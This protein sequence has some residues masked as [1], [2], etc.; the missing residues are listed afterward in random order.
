MQTVLRFVA[1]AACLTVEQQSAS[2]QDKPRLLA[3]DGFMSK[4]VFTELDPEQMK[5]R[6]SRADIERLHLDGN[7]TG[8]DNILGLMARSE[9]MHSRIAEPL[10]VRGE[11]PVTLPPNATGSEAY[12]TCFYAFNLNGLALAGSGDSLILIRP[13]TRPEAPRTERK[14]NRDEI[15]PIRLFR[16]GYLRSDLV[17][18]QYKDKLGTRAGRA[19]LE[20]KSNTVIIADKAASLEKL[21]RYIDAEALE[22]MGLPA[23]A[24]RTPADRL[25]LPS[26]GAIASTANIHFYLMAFARVSQIPMRASKTA[27]TFD[28]HYREADVWMGETDYR[29]LESEYNRVNEYSQLALR[30]NGQNWPVPPDERTLTPAEQNKLDIHFGVVSPD[31]ANAAPAKSKTKKSTRRR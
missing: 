24:G 10:E 12:T 26:L 31:P 15:L 4:G 7:S 29:A 9:K 28:R 27:R 22:S 19:I 6:L 13:E 21:Q 3:I 14:W 23:G 2:A 18:A 8:I 5:R 11:I 17:L 20:A 16:L 1:I 30:N 25:R